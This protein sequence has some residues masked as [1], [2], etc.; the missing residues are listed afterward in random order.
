MNPICPINQIGIR[1]AVICNDGYMYEEKVLKQWMK[2]SMTSPITRQLLDFVKRCKIA[3]TCY[4]EFF[5]C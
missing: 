3:N 1:H 2:K 4:N 5:Y